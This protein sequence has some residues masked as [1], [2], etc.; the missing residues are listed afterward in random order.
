MPIIDFTLKNTDY[1]SDLIPFKNT[2][3]SIEVSLSVG[4]ASSVC[5]DGA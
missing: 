4:A 2:A 3:L 5:R 1:L